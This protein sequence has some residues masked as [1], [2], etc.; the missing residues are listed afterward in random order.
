MTVPQLVAFYTILSGLG[1]T[2]AALAFWSGVLHQK[3]VSQGREIRELK[4]A[5]AG[6]RGDRDRLIIIETTLANV[7]DSQDSMK[8]AL[9]GLQRQL[10]NLMRLKSGE[11]VELPVQG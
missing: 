9:D 1:A 8:R 6:E 2:V 7:R 11:I 5:K 4:D 3:V 10:G